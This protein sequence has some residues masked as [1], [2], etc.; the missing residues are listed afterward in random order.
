[1]VACRYILELTFVPH[2]PDLVEQ[3]ATHVY[4][5]IQN[6]AP[7]SYRRRRPISSNSMFPARV[8]LQQCFARFFLIVLT[9]SP[10]CPFNIV[11]SAQVYLVGATLPDRGTKSA[12][13][14]L[15]SRMPKTEVIRSER[16]A[17]IALGN[18]LGG[19]VAPLSFSPS[20]GSSRYL[21]FLLSLPFNLLCHRPIFK[22]ARTSG[23]PQP[24]IS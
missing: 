16:Y 3:H 5:L 9:P 1:M 2:Y 17:A 10:R 14:D 24:A 18:A 20:L 12:M 19:P 8:R 4:R 22:T 23:T 6:L 15:L 7:R 11:P 21:S 13:E